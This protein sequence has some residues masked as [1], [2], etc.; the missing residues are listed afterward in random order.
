MQR[1]RL[2]SPHVDERKSPATD[3][4]VPSSPAAPKGGGRKLHKPHA[5]VMQQLLVSKKGPGNRPSAKS[6]NSCCPLCSSKDCGSKKSCFKD[7]SHSVLRNLLV[8]GRDDSE[9]HYC[10]PSSNQ[11]PERGDANHL[12]QSR[13]S[14]CDSAI[15]KSI[16]CLTKAASPKSFVINSYPSVAAK[17]KQTISETSSAETKSRAKIIPLSP[18]ECVPS[19]L[20]SPRHSLNKSSEG[21]SITC[22]RID[23]LEEYFNS[24]GV[25]SCSVQTEPEQAHSATIILDGT[26]NSQPMKPL[27]LRKGSAKG[28]LKLVKLTTRRTPANLLRKI[29]KNQTFVPS[30]SVGPSILKPVRRD[31]QASVSRYPNILPKVAKLFL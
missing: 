2:C 26:P 6:P 16:S 22:K 14:S 27:Y 7:S 13:S 3:L 21:S 17:S 29:D 23:S 4:G 19:L 8:S 24:Q 18:T 5:P 1:K 20:S 12:R 25:A 31:G 10:L 28:D 9:T 15:K 30:S 11:S